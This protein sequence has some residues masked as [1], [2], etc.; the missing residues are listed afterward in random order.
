MDT[1]I[2]IVEA[3]SKHGVDAS[4]LAG[5]LEQESRWNPK[6]V[7]SSNAKGLAQFIDSTAEEFGVNPFECS[8]IDG[9]ARY[10]AYLID[11]YKGDLKK[12]I[13]ACNGGLGNIDKFGVGFNEEN[14][15]Y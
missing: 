5:L 4:I 6:A 9:A 8:A 12:A 15:D 14:A 1:V 7:S 2:L 11:Y 3:A 10:L 13:Y